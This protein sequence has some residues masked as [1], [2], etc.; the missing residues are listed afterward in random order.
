MNYTKKKENIVHLPFY[1][2]INDTIF[3]YL[4]GKLASAF[5]EFVFEGAII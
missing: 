3:Y 5:I 1:K 2:V 4:K